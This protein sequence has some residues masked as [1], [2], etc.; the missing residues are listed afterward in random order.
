MEKLK[1]QRGDKPTKS[2]NLTIRL[3]PEELE[4]I[5]NLKQ[6]MQFDS[7]R[8]LLLF[9]L[10]IL[11]TLAKWQSKSYMFLLKDPE[12]GFTEVEFELV[13]NSREGG[14]PILTT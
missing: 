8:D 13:P 1:V 9:G 14:A 2:K 12:G 11:D 4:E 5:G 6:T 7:T 3:T 10:E